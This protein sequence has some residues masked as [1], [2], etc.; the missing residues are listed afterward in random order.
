MSMEKINIPFN[1]YAWKLKKKKTQNRM[2]IPNAVYNSMVSM[3]LI[4]HTVS[5]VIKSDK[6]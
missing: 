4:L 1:I 6:L 3:Y 2:I 5:V